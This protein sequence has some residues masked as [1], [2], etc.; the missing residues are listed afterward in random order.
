MMGM[1]GPWR[2]NVVG[3]AG[4]GR[5][6]VARALRGAGI[7]V[8]S[9]GDAADIDVYVF[10][11]TLNADDLAALASSTRPAVAVLNKADLTGFGDGAPAERCAALRRETGVA[12]C[13]LSALLAVAGFDPEVLDEAA[14]EALRT[15]A[16][17]ATSALGQAA[18]WRLA[19]ELDV[20]GTALAVAAVR[21]GA[22]RAAIAELLRAVSGIDALIGEID[23]AGAVVGYHGAAGPA[24]IAAAGAV[25]C[26]AGAPGPAVASSDHLARAL[27]W[28][29]YAR[30]PVSALHRACALDVA[31]GAL[32]LWVQAGG[33][34][35]ALP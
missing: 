35:A 30:G 20:F 1:D 2:V 15:L 24:R 14:L 21:D 25:L 16:G 32:Q 22:G 8:V 27:H 33:R 23:R 34:P 5:R 7:P 10:V 31:R 6:T 26:A 4:A 17:G 11:E 3:R 9:P 29:R 18:R 28:H 19:A 12:V 13:P